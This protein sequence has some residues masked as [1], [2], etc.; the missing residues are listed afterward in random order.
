MTKNEINCTG[1][2]FYDVYDTHPL[3]GAF[4]SSKPA[5]PIFVPYL[6]R[7]VVALNWHHA[8]Q[9]ALTEAAQDA[10]GDLKRCELCGAHLRY[11]ALFFDANERL[12]VVGKE[13]ANRVQSG[14]ADR[15]EWVIV[16]AV[17]EAK[18]MMTKNGMRWKVDLKEPNG[19][20][21]I[22]YDQRPSYASTWTP[23]RPAG[24][25]RFTYGTPRVT[26]WASNQAE[27]LDIVRQFRQFLR[28][29]N[30]NAAS[31]VKPRRY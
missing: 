2:E 15:E 27:L 3:P 30:L 28:D 31:V 14:L 25:G 21:L 4:V 17:K 13:C 22:P 18:Q 11:A 8:E 23:K 24:R 26:L 7:T 5:E 29:K 6:K 9:Q 1:W 20:R 10:G 16:A 19:Y 12:H